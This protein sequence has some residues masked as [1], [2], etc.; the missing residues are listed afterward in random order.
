[1]KTLIVTIL[2]LAW[3]IILNGSTKQNYSEWIAPAYADTLKNIFIMDA[4]S[5]SEGKKIYENACWTCH[6]L[7]G[8]GDGPAAEKLNPKPADHTSDKIQKQ[9][10]GALFWKMSKGRG[11]MLPLEKSL[12]KQQRWKLVCYIRELGKQNGTQ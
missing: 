11:E 6:G 5:I 7:D 4:K 3:W 2:I 8:K 1:M 9:S 10:D 12:S